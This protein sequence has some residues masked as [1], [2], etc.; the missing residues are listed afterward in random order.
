MN[1]F[2]LLLGL[3]AA[4]KLSDNMSV[5]D[6]VEAVAKGGNKPLGPS[7]KI[8]DSP[9]TMYSVYFYQLVRKA[10]ADKANTGE[11]KYRIAKYQKGWTAPGSATQAEVDDWTTRCVEQLFSQDAEQLL[12]SSKANAWTPAQNHAAL[13]VLQK[14]WV[15]STLATQAQVD[16]WSKTAFGGSD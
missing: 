13:L 5:L 15:D 4:A 9:Q 16:A 2:L 6:D 1:P 8:G 10:R 3:L 7:K 14:S 11:L 12:A